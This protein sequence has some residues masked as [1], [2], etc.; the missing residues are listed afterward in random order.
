MLQPFSDYVSYRT[1][2]ATEQIRYLAPEISA[3]EAV[4]IQ[5]AEFV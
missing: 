4:E 3:I 5:P 1:L 2:I